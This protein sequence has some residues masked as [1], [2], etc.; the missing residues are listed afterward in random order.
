[1]YA[2]VIVVCHLFLTGDN[3]IKKKKRELE[4]WE[5]ALG[6]PNKIIFIYEGCEI[7]HSLRWKR[8]T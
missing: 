7:L 3:K 8:P 5:V 6:N 2:T 1:M 4:I